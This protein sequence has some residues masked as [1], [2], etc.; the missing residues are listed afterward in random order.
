MTELK[1]MYYQHESL[2]ADVIIGHMRGTF[3]EID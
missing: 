1:L 3:L 2:A